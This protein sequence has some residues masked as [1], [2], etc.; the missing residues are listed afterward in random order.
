MTSTLAERQREQTGLDEPTHHTPI[1]PEQ[2]VI[3]P[4]YQRVISVCIRCG[5]VWEQGTI[6]ALDC[7]TCGHHFYDFPPKRR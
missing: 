7:P 6:L 4:S 1:M 2:K 5:H 3:A